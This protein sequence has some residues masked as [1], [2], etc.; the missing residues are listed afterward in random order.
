MRFSKPRLSRLLKLSQN[1][2][3]QVLLQNQ[4]FRFYQKR[5]LKLSWAEFITLSE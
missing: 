5:L 3:G 4:L 1:Q 2:D